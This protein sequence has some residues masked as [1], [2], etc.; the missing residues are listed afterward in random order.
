MNGVAFFTYIYIYIS[1][2][3]GGAFSIGSGIA[4]PAV[5]G[6]SGEEFVGENTPA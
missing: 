2:R 4:F 5:R 3:W 1:F 6:M